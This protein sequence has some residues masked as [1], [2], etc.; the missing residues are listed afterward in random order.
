MMYINTEI[1]KYFLDILI[2]VNYEK[3]LITKA[4][5]LEIRC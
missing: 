1:V 3:I 5:K 4:N 2:F